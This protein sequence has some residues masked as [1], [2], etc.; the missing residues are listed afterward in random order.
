MEPYNVLGDESFKNVAAIESFKNVATIAKV[1]PS[2]GRTKYTQKVQDAIFRYVYERFPEL[3]FIGDGIY[4]DMEQYHWAAGHSWQSIK[5]HY[6]DILLPKKA[7][8]L[9]FLSGFWF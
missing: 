3:D 9:L 5:S 6:K 4:K 1:L 2:N 8:S 7:P